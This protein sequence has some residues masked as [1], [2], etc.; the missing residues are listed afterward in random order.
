LRGFFRG[1]NGV[2]TVKGE[3]GRLASRIKIKKRNSRDLFGYLPCCSPGAGGEK[4]N[5]E[6]P[7][8]GTGKGWKLEEKNESYIR[9]K[10]G[11]RDSSRGW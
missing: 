10:R 3:K 4:A 6:S 1:E 5:L 2:R 8:G 9:E 7:G 11:E